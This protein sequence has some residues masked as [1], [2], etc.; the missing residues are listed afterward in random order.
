MFINV[1]TNYYAGYFRLSRTP[2]MQA[3]ALI[4]VC[5]PPGPTLSYRLITVQIRTILSF[6]RIYRTITP[7]FKTGIFSRMAGIVRCNERSK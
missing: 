2:A 6:Y 5:H 3:L 7:F 4:A 1:N